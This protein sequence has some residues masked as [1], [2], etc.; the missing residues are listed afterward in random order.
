MRYWRIVTLLI[1]VLALAGCNLGTSDDDETPEP[2]VTATQDTAARPSVTITSPNDGDDVIT[3]DTVRI[4]V[5]TGGGAEVVELFVNGTST[6]EVRI[7][8]PTDNTS[9][10]LLTFIPEQTGTLNVRV[11]AYRDNTSSNPDEIQ[12][13]ARQ[14]QN[15]PTSL[16]QVPTIDAND[17]TCRAQVNANLNF[18]RAPN[19]E[20]EVIRVLAGGEMLP[21]VGRLSD[22]SWLQLR[23]NVTLG[24][25]SANFVT[26]LGNCS[27]IVVVNPPATATPLPSATPLSS[28]TPLPSSTPQPTEPPPPDLVVANITGPE[29]VV[30]PS[31]DSS[32]TV[33]YSV[34]LT[35]I[36]GPITGSFSAEGELLPGNDTFDF[37]AVG[38]LGINQSISLDGEVIFESAGTF[39]L[40]ITVDSDDDI[41]ESRENN[42]VLVINVTV[43]NE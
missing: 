26:R 2:L 24:W 12:L 31:G 28:T 16:P 30:I 36:G 29:D 9:R 33:E 32:V 38:N 37:G 7:G 42:N 41:N 34:T 35:N 40:Q 5:S 10:S 19:T 20:S 4:E 27:G 23:S 25:V 14:G 21:I 17:P 43:T 3:N 13:I 1:A 22:N 15:N 6:Q 11:V 8:S 18:R 39:A